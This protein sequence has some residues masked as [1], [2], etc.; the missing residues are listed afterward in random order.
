MMTKIN[1]LSEKCFLEFFSPTGVLVPIAVLCTAAVIMGLIFMWCRKKSHVRLVPLQTERDDKVGRT[2]VQLSS[3]R[4]DV[5][6]VEGIF[7]SFNLIPIA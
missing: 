7:F 2:E 1:E 5:A 3:I 4:K 6:G